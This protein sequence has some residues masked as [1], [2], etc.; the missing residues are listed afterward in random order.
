MFI[1]YKQILPFLSHIYFFPGILLDASQILF[2]VCHSPFAV[3]ML[4]LNIDF[5]YGETLFWQLN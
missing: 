4:Q 1:F 3:R 2:Y 5:Y